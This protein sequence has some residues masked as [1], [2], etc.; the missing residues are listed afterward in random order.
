MPLELDSK[1]NLNGSFS[2]FITDKNGTDWLSNTIRGEKADS[3]RQKDVA[4]CTLEL[5]RHIS[6]QEEADGRNGIYVPANVDEK[7]GNT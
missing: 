2:G 7:N 3:E 5:G 6:F 1:T 4:R